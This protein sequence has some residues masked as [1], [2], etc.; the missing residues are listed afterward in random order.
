VI[1]AAIGPG[2]S[3]Q[4]LA[5]DYL[6]D[7]WRLGIFGGRIRWDN[8]A[9][10]LTQE[11][12]PLDHDVSVFAGLRGGGLVAGTWIEL[13]WTGA[14]RFNFMFQNDARAFGVPSD[15]DVNNQTLQL[16]VTPAALRH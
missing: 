7:W 16:T 10:Y 13:E 12:L 11:P 14:K 4:W 9:F 8:D 6:A 2:A 1:G 5:A 15:W 3:S